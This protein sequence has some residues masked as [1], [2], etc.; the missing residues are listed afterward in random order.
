MLSRMVLQACGRPSAC[1][2]GAISAT[3]VSVG[4]PRAPYVLHE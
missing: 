3:T 4:M 1:S 2:S